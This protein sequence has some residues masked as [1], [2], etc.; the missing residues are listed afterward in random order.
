MH[1]PWGALPSVASGNLTPPSLFT[2]RVICQS[3]RHKG[4]GE[5]PYP[6]HQHIAQNVMTTSRDTPSELRK[7]ELGHFR[8]EHTLG[9]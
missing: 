1:V 2:N 9:P 4:G 6:S 8:V 7:P 3:L 5:T